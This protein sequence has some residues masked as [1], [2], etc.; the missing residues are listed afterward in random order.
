MSF[1][2]IIY[3]F[4]EGSTWKA[5]SYRALQERNA[6]ILSA[7]PHE[8]TWPPLARGMFSFPSWSSLEGT[9]RAQVISIAAS[10]KNIELGDVG[11][12]VTKLEALLAQL[13]WL[14]AR[15]HLLTEVMGAYR[16][17]Y[18]VSSDVLSS[19][20]TESPTPTRVWKRRVFRDHVELSDSEIR[21]WFVDA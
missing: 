3:G 20:P 6:Q 7:L 16:L 18:E 5:E 2:T 8:D 17:E 19:Y 9:H 12:W 11:S 4:I 13:Y 1:E 15:V 21:T 14:Q 10:M